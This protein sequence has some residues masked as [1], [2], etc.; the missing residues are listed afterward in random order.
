MSVYHSIRGSMQPTTVED[1]DG[2]VLVDLSAEP[3][4]PEMETIHPASDRVSGQVSAN[5]KIHFAMCNIKMIPTFSNIILI[6]FQT[7]QLIGRNR[8][9]NH[10][11]HLTAQQVK[12][13]IALKH[14]QK[15]HDKKSRQQMCRN[16]M[17]RGNKVRE[18]NSKGGRQKRSD[19]THCKIISRANNNRKC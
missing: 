1:Q 18:V 14:S 16:A 3:D 5:K 15:A 6:F 10:G 17:E 12:Q 19:M 9:D 8:V 2:L 4:M 13:V 7:M 11:S